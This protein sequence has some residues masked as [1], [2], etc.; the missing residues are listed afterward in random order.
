M[1]LVEISPYL[2]ELQAKRL[3][4]QTTE[5][6]KEDLDSVPYYRKGESVS[7]IKIYWYRELEQVPKAFSIYLAHE[8]FDAMPVHKFV[9]VEKNWKE[10]LIGMSKENKNQ[11]DYITSN[12]MTPMLGVFLSRPWI[13]KH[14]LPEHIEYSAETEKTVDMM[15]DR[16]QEDGGI[17]LIMDY[18]HIGEKGDTFRVSMIY[19]SGVIFQ[20]RNGKFLFLYPRLSKI[21]NCMIH[22]WILVLRI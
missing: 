22:W 17:G 8:F 11:F 21:I 2:S 15:A 18:G 14:T 19:K 4:C 1:H 12:A 5:T 20:L 13:D 7:G 9:Q 6:K 16:I 10:I 3:C